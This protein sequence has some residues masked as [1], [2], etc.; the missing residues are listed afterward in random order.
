MAEKN[1][2]RMTP[3]QIEVLTVIRDYRHTEGCSPSLQEIADK[4]GVGKV[5][6]FGHVAKLVAE[7]M[8]KRRCFVARSLELTRLAKLPQ[9]WRPTLEQIEELVGP[10]SEKQA[11]KLVGRL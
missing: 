8:L 5:T 11:A 4:M 9:Y 1:H 3:R 7:G 6:V 2:F 10:L